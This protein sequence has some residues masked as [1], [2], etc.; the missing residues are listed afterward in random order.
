MKKFIILLFIGLCFVSTAYSDETLTTKQKEARE[1]IEKVRQTDNPTLQIEYYTKAIGLNPQHAK[2]YNNRGL[3]YAD[4]G[5]YDQAID[6]YTK[7]TELDPKLAQAYYNRGVVYAIRDFLST[8]C[9]D[10]YQAGILHLKQNDR[11]EALKCVDLMK[12]VGPSSPLIK[13]L[14]NK[15]HGEDKPKKSKK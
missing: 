1:W 12:E 5:N 15:I 10:F 11:T 9:D 14:M 2:A 13:K 6:N 7:A 3:A 4:K 8:A